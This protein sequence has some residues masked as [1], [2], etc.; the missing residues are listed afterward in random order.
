MNR[1]VSLSLPNGLVIL[2]DEVGAKRHDPTRSDTVRILIL[3][4]L[5]HLNYLPKDEMKALG[6]LGKD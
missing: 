3:E 5:A 6:V 4:A 2:I 1:S